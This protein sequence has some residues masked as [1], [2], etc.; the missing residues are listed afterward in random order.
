MLINSAEAGPSFR[1]QLS[2][3][4]LLTHGLIDTL[5][6]RMNGTS[7]TYTV[8]PPIDIVLTEA[9][10]E[11]IITTRI[12]M[13]FLSLTGSL[14]VLGL[15]VKYKKYY[16]PQRLIMLLTICNLG[17]AISSLLSF[18]TFSHEYDR[19]STSLLSI[20]SYHS[21]FHLDTISYF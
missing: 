5:F 11:V 15:M 13:A 7:P 20:S 2:F 16:G 21:Y 14:C 12:V 3:H 17:D 10:K 9:Q 1:S 19:P 4:S 8:G 6:N 18:G